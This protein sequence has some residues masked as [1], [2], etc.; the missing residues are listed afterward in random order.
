MN[1]E[2]TKVYNST[3]NRSLSKFV[4]LLYT[5]KTFSVKTMFNYYF[6]KELNGIDY[7]CYRI[8]EL[9]GKL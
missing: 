2:T 6:C 3:F 5:K 9:F 8:N 7:I 1:A 4:A